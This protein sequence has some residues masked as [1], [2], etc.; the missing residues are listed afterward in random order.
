MLDLPEYVWRDIEREL[1]VT[2]RKRIRRGCGNDMDLVVR[3]ARF[4]EQISRVY[5][6]IEMAQV[7]ARRSA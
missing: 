4:R 2:M 6:M 5:D 3:R 7:K 1:L